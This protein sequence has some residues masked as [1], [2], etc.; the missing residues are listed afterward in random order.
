M[1]KDTKPGLLK[2]KSSKSLCDPLSSQKM[3]EGSAFLSKVSICG[4]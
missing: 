2:L 1:L 3:L 4:G